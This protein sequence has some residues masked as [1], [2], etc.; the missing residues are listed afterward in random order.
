MP[1][2][3]TISLTFLVIFFISGL[4]YLA[5]PAQDLEALA[6]DVISSCAE[7]GDKPGCYEQRVPQMYPAHSISQLFDVIRHIR[8]GDPS[9]QF[10][11][12]LAH[13]LGERVV[14]EDPQKWLDAIPLNPTD[15]MCSNGFIHGVVGG[16]F[17]AEVLDDA[18]LEKHI[19]DF[20]R[21]CEPR[22]SWVPTPLDQAICYHGMGHLYDFITDA[23]IP[24]ALELC[25]RTT[26]TDMHRVCIEGV[27]MQ[28]YQPLEPDD[29]LMI[30]QMPVKPKKSTVRNFC[31][32]Y[33]NPDYEGA[34]LRESWPFFRED[35]ID[36]G[37][38]EVFCSG[39]PNEQEE[40]KC[41]QSTFAIIGRMTLNDPKKAAHICER[42]SL[43]LQSLCFSTVARAI[44]EEDR[45]DGRGASDMCARAPIGI[46]E[47]CYVSLADT[48]HSMYG[49]WR[50]LAQFCNALPPEYRAACQ[51]AR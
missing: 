19:P 43:D 3:K 7:S 47:Q 13:K 34:C 2:I 32:A 22:Q 51:G 42:I 18:T 9:Y 25:E 20:R 5:P 10:C 4:L 40:M 27:F 38:V 14:A 28:I 11:H 35:I 50:A 21:A 23:D 39:Q 6:K 48:A 49:S 33:E 45:A 17:R 36:G 29:F 15:G 26:R 24:K 1:R 46:Q 16:R 37:K 44:V 12:V 30:E 41:F 31:S 8:T